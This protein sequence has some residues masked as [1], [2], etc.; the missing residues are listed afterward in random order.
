MG[1]LRPDMCGLLHICDGGVPARGGLFEDGLDG[2]TE[3][4]CS[5]E[6]GALGDAT[7][8]LLVTSLGLGGMGEMTDSSSLFVY[9]LDE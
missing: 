7:P 8:N 6:G 2:F 1:S 5:D 4:A 9:C 3:F